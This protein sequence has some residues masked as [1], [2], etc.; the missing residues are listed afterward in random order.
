MDLEASSIYI[1]SLSIPNR[2]KALKMVK[3]I[4]KTFLTFVSIFLRMIKTLFS[5]LLLFTT[6]FANAQEFENMSPSR[7]LIHEKDISLLSPIEIL[8]D[9][10]VF[11][12]DSMY[13]S[14]LDESRID[15]SYEFIRV[16]KE[17]IKNKSS[18]S[19]PLNKLKE[20]IVIINAPD[21]SF[22]IYNWEIIRSP[23]ERRYYGAIQTNQG[24]T[25]PLVDISDQI[26]RGAEDSL[27]SNTRWYGNL[28]YNILDKEVNGQKLYFLF[29]WN[30]NSMNCERKMV[31]AFQFDPNGKGLF[32]APIFSIL[33][34]GK[35]KTSNRLLLECQKGA[36]VSMNY[37]TETQ[38]IIFDHCESQ[39][40]DPAKKYTYV[41]DGTYDGLRW[42]GNQWIMNENIVQ[43][44]ILKDGEAPVDKPIIK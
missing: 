8:E 44:T 10:L 31:D 23:V 7:Q 5:F 32:G 34:R 19:A 42:D 21:N 38:Q 39:I 18:F 43:I 26:I 20:K 30:G 41:P 22:K 12:A 1:Q 25:I 13:F 15:G 3:R 4:L 36:K 14:S 24:E 28:Y 40:G 2:L 6:V 33:D 37:D 17:L 35:R 9:S 11:L 29:G 16:F 27:F